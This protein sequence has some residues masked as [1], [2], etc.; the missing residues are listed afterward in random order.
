VVRV[1][2]LF[3][4]PATSGLSSDKCT[5]TEFL[6][7]PYLW[8]LS[9]A[10]LVVFGVKTACTDWGQLFLIQDKGQSTLMGRVRKG[11]C[12]HMM[13]MMYIQYIPSY[14]N[15]LQ[16]VVGAVVLAHC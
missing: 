3:T 8:L 1:V 13:H 2:I 14:G 16:V 7:S 6:L 10:F 5:L 15:R 11:L 12:M 9:C 4:L